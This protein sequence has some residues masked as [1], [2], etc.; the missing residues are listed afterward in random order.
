[1][2]YA[3]KGV[4]SRA[5]INFVHMFK[6]NN[7]VYPPYTVDGAPVDGTSGTLA[8]IAEPGALLIRIDSPSVYQ[9][10]NTKASP[11][12]TLFSLTS[13]A[14]DF[15]GSFQGTVGDV[16]PSTGVFTAIDGPVG[17]NT[18]AAGAFTTLAAATLAIT[19]LLTKSIANALTAA[20]SSRAD[21]L[22]LTKQVNRITT[23]AASTGVVLPAAAAGVAIVVFNDGANPVQVYAPGS[24]TIDGT[25]GATGVALTN[26][27]RC[28]YFGVA[29]NTY[30]SAQLGV[31]SA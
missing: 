6:S 10:T 11:T 17:G 7:E 24:D 15:T 31:V 12:W 20:G 27:K 26:A 4:L 19:G 5:R 14:G 22:A 23:A 28:V 13:G 1:M 9:N 3:L 29:A 18:P 25:A 2:A 30:I 21:A 8:G 16:T